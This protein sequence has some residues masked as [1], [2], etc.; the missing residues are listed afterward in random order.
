MRRMLAALAVVALTASPTAGA[1]TPPKVDAGVAPPSGA[2]GPVTTFAQRSA[3]VTAGVLPGTDPAAA[4]PNRAMLDLSAAWDYSRGDGQLVAVIDTGVRPG[5]RLPNVDPGGD[6]VESTD[7][8]T[9]C[10]GHGTLV[11]GLIAG[12]PGA[13]GF[14]GVAPGARLLSIR[15]TSAR[16]SPRDTSGSAG[17]DPAVARADV[18]I[19]TLARAI[20]RAADLGARVINISSVTCFPAG[21][22]VD[23]SAL[24]AAL[25]YATI[26]KDAVVVAAAGNNQAGL[27]PGSACPSNPLSDPGR[28]EDPRNWD[29]VTSVSM[30]SVWDQYVLS[31]GSLTPT[32]KP[33]AFTM[34]GPWVGIAAPGEFIASVGNADGGGLANALPN[35]RGQLF[36]L[37][38]SGFAA[39]Y[40]SGVAALVRSRFPD[41]RA[42]QVVDRLT[43]SARGAARAPSNLIGTG[44]IDPVAALTWDVSAVTQDGATGSPAAVAAPAAPAQRDGTPRIIALAGTGVLVIGALITAAVAANR[45]KEIS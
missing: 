39:A 17:E 44:A 33:S 34:A 4:S 45:R 29:G 21:L 1:I 18:D 14:S 20:V 7:G 15:S 12:Q 32:G 26:D 8:L 27:N 5:P 37:L 2:A 36:P 42:Q 3:C 38:S 11:A 31:V 9:D 40:V 43:A 13:D 41:L 10:D 28:P 23:Q 30:P 6:F 25:R 19:T 24:G 16:F 22:D 35:D